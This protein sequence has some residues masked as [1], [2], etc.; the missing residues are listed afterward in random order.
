[1][2]ELSY[3]N[4]SIVAIGNSSSLLLCSGMYEACPVGNNPSNHRVLSLISV[5]IS[6]CFDH[7]IFTVTPLHSY[8]TLAQFNL[9]YCL[10]NS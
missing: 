4:L 1:M 10:F 2:Y 9:E 5:N 6:L 7:P 3:S 8:S